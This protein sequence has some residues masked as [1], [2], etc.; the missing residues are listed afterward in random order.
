MNELTLVRFIEAMRLNEQ[1]PTAE[2][3]IDLMAEEVEGF[4]EYPHLVA[5]FKKFTPTAYTRLEEALANQAELTLN[6]TPFKA[7][8]A[9]DPNG[10]AGIPQRVLFFRVQA[11]SVFA[12]IVHWETGEATTETWVVGDEA[13]AWQETNHLSYPWQEI[14]SPYIY[15][16]YLEGVVP[17]KSDELTSVVCRL[18]AD[19]LETKSGRAW[20]GQTKVETHW[21]QM[22]YRKYKK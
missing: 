7:L 12:E 14:V 19:L 1:N 11:G 3:Y 22:G 15:P 4:L 17:G 20:S 2:L 18:T 9:T 5:Y 16:V 6:T 10:V 13:D 8:V 21:E